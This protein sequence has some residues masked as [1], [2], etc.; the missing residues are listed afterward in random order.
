MKKK[1]ETI[2]IYKTEKGWIARFEDP[3]VFKLFGTLDL[4]T[5]FTETADSEAVVRHLEG[6]NPECIVKLLNIRNGP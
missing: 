5:P 1:R 2:F 4:P 3:N 6:R